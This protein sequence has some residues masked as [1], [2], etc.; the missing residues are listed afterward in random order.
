[1]I[2]RPPRSTRTDTLFPYTTLFRSSCRIRHLQKF[3]QLDKRIEVIMNT[4]SF[5]LVNNANG[6]K[7]DLPAVSGTLGPVGLD[8]GKVY[9]KTG[10]FTYD[11]GFSST[12][13]TQS[14]ITYIDGDKGVLLYRGYPVAQ[15]AEQCSFVEVAYLILNGELPNPAQLDR[16]ST[17]LNSSH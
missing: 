6:E 7:V 11:P 12:C 8:V 17:R 5:S 10:V 13:S 14:A 1:M 9:G 4:P 3:T 15:L 2:R 16:K